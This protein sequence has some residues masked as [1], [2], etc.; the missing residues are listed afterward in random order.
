[1]LSKA[2]GKEVVPSIIFHEI[3]LKIS[4]PRDIVPAAASSVSSDVILVPGIAVKSRGG[5]AI[6][7]K[8]NL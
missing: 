1:M 6:P 3:S 4:A 5:Q 2:D 8:K 7:Y